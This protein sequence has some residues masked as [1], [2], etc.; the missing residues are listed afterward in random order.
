MIKRTY[1][2][3][4]ASAMLLLGACDKGR[5]NK[6]SAD[7]DREDR[8]TTKESLDSIRV[9][10]AMDLMSAVYDEEELEEE[11]YSWETTDS[12]QLE[13]LFAQIPQTRIEIVDDV[14]P[15]PIKM[16]VE[17]LYEGHE[18]I[19][20]I[21]EIIERVYEVPI[22]LIEPE[23]VKPAPPKPVEEEIFK[24][25]DTPPVFPGGESALLSWLS[26]QLNYPINAQENGISGRV[27]VGFVIEKD[28]S[29]SNVQVVKGVDKDL[30]AEAVRVVKKMPKW[31]PGKNNGVP[32]R[33][34][35]NLP[36]AFILK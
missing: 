19:D 31:S 23:P 20:D 34:F 35:F 32:V 28:G 7:S 15:S 29:I 17:P 27:I 16:Q 21:E 14:K 10:S 11:E 24:V 6:W 36:V 5:N 8:G 18:Y 9:D 13:D 30:D 22:E 25:V 12:I 2:V 1:I 33:S 26:V 3:G 4:L